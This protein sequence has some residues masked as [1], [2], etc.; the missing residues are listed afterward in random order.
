M[1]GGVFGGSHRASQCVVLRGEFRNALA[2]I[3]LFPL[4]PLLRCFKFL[5]R[6]VDL[7]MGTVLRGA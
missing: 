6:L 3:P 1:G 2:V 5:S 4:Q 7:L